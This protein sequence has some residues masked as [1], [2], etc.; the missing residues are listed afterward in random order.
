V[1]TRKRA[2]CLARLRYRRAQPCFAIKRNGEPRTRLQKVAFDTCRAHSLISFAKQN[3][4][5]V[6]KIAPRPVEL[7]YT[8]SNEL[9]D[10]RRSNA[11]SLGAN[12]ICF[13]LQNYP[14]YTKQLRVNVGEDFHVLPHIIHIYCGSTQRYSP[15]KT[16]PYRPSTQESVFPLALLNAKSIK[17]YHCSNRILGLTP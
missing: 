7:F 5:N 9:R 17:Q 4:L 2:N 12:E 13:A 11:P 15:T 10:S 6:H 14:M 8:R 16:P 3:N 1:R